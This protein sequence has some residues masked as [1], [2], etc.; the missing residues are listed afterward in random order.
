MSSTADDRRP[1]SVAVS[2]SVP[3][4]IFAPALRV[5][6]SGILLIVTLIA[7]EAIAV[8]AALPTAA[9]A[10]HGLSSYGWAFTGFLV[11]N[12]V[13]MVASGQICDARGPRL[14]LIGG[15]VAFLGGLLTSGTAAQ[16]WQLVL[17]RVVQGLGGGLLITAI[18]VVIGT[19]YPGELSAKVFAAFASAWVLPSLI[20]PLAAGTLAEH[21]SWRWVFLGLVPFV[22][23]GAAALVPALR[24][25]GPAAAVEGARLSARRLVSAFATALGVAALENAGQHR[26]IVAYVLGAAGLLAV[27]WGLRTLLP[28]GTIRVRPGVSAP[29]ALRG[30]L[31]GAFFGVDALLPLTL[32]LQHDYSPTAAA[33]PLMVAG[34]AWAIGSWWQGRP[35]VAETGRRHVIRAGFLF[36]GLGAV[37]VALAAQPDL[38]GGLAYLAWSVAGLGAGLAMSSVSVLLLDFTTPADRG[39]DSAALQIAD[40]VSSAVTTGIGGVLIAAAASGLLGYTAAFTALDLT[41]AALAVIGAALASRARCATC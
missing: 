5:T 18:Y 28:T 13:G 33:V 8:A 39:S 16:M 1:S 15:L 25:I 4:T 11:A 34:P 24:E 30:L 2:D 32:T 38:P 7:F 41:M 31:A 14:P 36:V 17:G 40:V 27:I 20:G 22:L 37:L 23:V 35:R 3:T 10:V 9:R 21:A 6:T 26:S 19:R 12:V 29:V